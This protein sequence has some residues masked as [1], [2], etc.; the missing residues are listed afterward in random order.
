MDY[1]SNRIDR[2]DDYYNS[3]K[4]VHQEM[5]LKQAVDDLNLKV[6]RTRLQFVLLR[7]NGGMAS[8]LLD[9]GKKIVDITR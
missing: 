4:T 5:F 9:W 3:G 8:E 1:I 7:K 2:L 6:C